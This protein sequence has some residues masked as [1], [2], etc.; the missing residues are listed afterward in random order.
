[1]YDS[2]CQFELIHQILN[3]QQAKQADRRCPIGQAR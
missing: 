3:E 2:S 1:M